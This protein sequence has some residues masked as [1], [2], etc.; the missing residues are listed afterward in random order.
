MDLKKPKNDFGNKKL[1]IEKISLC[2]ALG[3]KTI[4]YI[5]VYGKP[6]SGFCYVLTRE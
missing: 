2:P 1:P 5:G 4:P 3:L 6:Y